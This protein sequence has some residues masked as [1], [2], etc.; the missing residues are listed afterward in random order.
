MI[1]VH[2][3]VST[4]LGIG[5]MGKGGGTVAAVATC[6]CLYAA[7]PAGG[8]QLVNWLPVITLLL[9]VLGVWSANEVEPYWGKDDKKV[10]ID[11]VAGM[12]ITMLFIPVT[13]STL[14]V[15]LVLFRF[16]DIVKPL[17]I[18]KLEKVRGGLGVMLDDVVAGVYANIILQLLFYFNIL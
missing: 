11:E 14:L 13:L 5:Y 17:Y 16:F 12:L 2:K 4:S 6:L 1:R 10:V 18:R 9:T 8:S 3:L 7:Q 15:G